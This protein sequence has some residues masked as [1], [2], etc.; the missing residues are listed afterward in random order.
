MKFISS[1]LILVYLSLCYPVAA[2][3][4]EVPLSTLTNLFLSVEDFN[5][6]ANGMTVA[7]IDKKKLEQAWQSDES[8]PEN[9]DPKG[10]WGTPSEGFRLSLRFAKPE[11]IYGKPIEAIVLARNV[12]Q[13]NLNYVTYGSDWDLHFLVRDSKNR[14][15]Q[16]LHPT[17]YY[18]T[19]GKELVVFP[20]TQR[21][22][23]VNLS[24]HFNFDSPGDYNV[25]V[26]A[27]VPKLVK[28][29]L[30]DVTSGTAT[31]KIPTSGP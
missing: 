14:L 12:S 16:D 10:N 26:Q 21:R 24:R 4:I 5:F 8:R 29:G 15:L 22:F 27:R 18:G 13:Q 6:A 19:G 20:R 25:T 9:Q 28:G 30:S 7:Y 2:Q 11:Y 17:D 31:L 3:T 1:I 23:T